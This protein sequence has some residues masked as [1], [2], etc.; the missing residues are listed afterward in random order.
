M[1]TYYPAYCSTQDGITVFI[2]K[3]MKT[4]I[5]KKV[6]LNKSR[7]HTIDLTDLWYFVKF[8][9]VYVAP[10]RNDIGIIKTGDDVIM[11]ER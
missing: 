3:A 2:C 5:G 1:L 6:A 11:I 4:K 9:G 7:I 8:I 10:V